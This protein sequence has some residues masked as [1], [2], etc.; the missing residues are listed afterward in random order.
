MNVYLCGLRHHM[1]LY[2]PNCLDLEEES[3]AS[4][5]LGFLWWYPFGMLATI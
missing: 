4:E 2:F 3:R 1:V 5:A